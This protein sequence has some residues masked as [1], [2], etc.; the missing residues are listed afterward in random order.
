MEYLGHIF[1]PV[2]LGIDKTNFASLRDAQPPTNKT[3]LGTL[4]GLCN[5]YQCFIY[6]FTGRAHPLNKRLKKGAPDSVAFNDE[7]KKSSNSLIDEVCSQ[8]ILDLQKSKLPYSLYCDAS[9]YG[10]RCALF[11]TYPNDER[12][13]IGFWSRSLLPAVKN[14][15]PLNA[16]ALQSFGD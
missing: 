11:Q 12:K 2:R 4:F 14:T 8:P 6:A 9:N 10:I 5:F 3:Q 13:R 15:L 16:S 7:Q 1:K